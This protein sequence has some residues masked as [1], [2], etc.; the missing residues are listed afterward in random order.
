MSSNKP[1]HEMETRHLDLPA[2]DSPLPLRATGP[3]DEELPWVIEF[4]VVG[5]PATIQVQVHES[6]LIG[7][8]D[9]QRGVYPDVD[10]LPYG[11]QIK[12]VSREHALV[13]AKDNRITLRD[14][15]SVNGTR[16]NDHVLTPGQE[17]RLRD[18][19]N[20]TI[21]QVQLQV[22]FA[23]LPTFAQGTYDADVSH[24][25][26]PL[27]GQGEQI[28]VIEDD[29]DVSTVFRLALEHAGYKVKVVDTAVSAL[30]MASHGMPDA[31]ILDIMLPD[32]NINGIDLVR[33]F[34]KHGGTKLP[35][36]VVSGA[37]GG[38]QMKQAKEN[39]ADMYLGKPVSVDDLV[40]AV[41]SLLSHESDETTRLSSP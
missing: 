10:L 30:G 18:G 37:T 9:V 1:Q 19:D 40:R 29:H 36:I 16:L 26:I 22:R 8:G 14:L 25:T 4:R 31:V 23:V 3:L 11:G 35:V 28:L 15:N 32:T 12:G 13:I 24:A 33:Y 5:T 34:R 2:S 39:G 17:Y 7:R 21:G 20:L 38:Y 6:M 27:L 41:S